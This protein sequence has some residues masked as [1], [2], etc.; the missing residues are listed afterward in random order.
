MDL[1]IPEETLRTARLSASELRRDIAV[2]LFAEERLTLGQAAGLAEMS[3]S[4]F[5]HLLA[6][7]EI[8]AHYD[9]EDFDEDVATL[10]R[11]GRL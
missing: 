7:R 6:S 9:P 8:G 10:R 5:Q 11:L 2:Q 3:Q 4:A 1:V